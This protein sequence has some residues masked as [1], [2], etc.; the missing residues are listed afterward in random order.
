M[1]IIKPGTDARDNIE[2][3]LQAQRSG[4]CLGLLGQPAQVFAKKVFHG[5][6][7]F[8][9][10]AAK[11]VDL[12]DVFMLKQCRQ[13]GLIDKS[14]DQVALIRQVRQYFLDGN[15]FFKPVLTGNLGAIQLCHTADSNFL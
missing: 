9:A 1:R 2:G 10:E 7:I 13:F 14:L 12:N 15:Q 3:I 8:V 5:D 4:G 11:I 6:E